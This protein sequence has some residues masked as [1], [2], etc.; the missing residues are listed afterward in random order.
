[1]YPY[2]VISKSGN[3]KYV[4]DYCENFNDAKKAAIELDRETRLRFP[5]ALVSFR[6]EQR[7]NLEWTNTGWRVGE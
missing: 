6:V 2:R 3:G 1:M 4:E 5:N 7:V